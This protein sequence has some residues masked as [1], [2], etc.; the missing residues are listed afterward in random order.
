MNSDNKNSYFKMVFETTR[1]VSSFDEVESI[2]D[3]VTDRVEPILGQVQADNET[4]IIY[5][6]NS[7]KKV[8]FLFKTKSRKRLSLLRNTINKYL[9]NGDSIS[10]KNNNDRLKFLY[11]NRDTPILESV[12][13]LTKSQFIE[14]FRKYKKDTTITIEGDIDSIID[15]SGKDIEIFKEKDSWFKWQRKLHDLLYTEYNTI[16]DACDRSIILIIDPV[17]C[18]GK[19]KF[20]KYLY[21]KDR[22]NIGILNE[23]SASQLKANMMKIAGKKIYFI[24]LPR[25]SG[26]LGTLGLM[27]SLEMLKNGFLNS[28][29]RGASSVAICEPPHIV[30]TTNHMPEGNLSVDRWQCFEIMPNKDW[31]D[32]TEKNKKFAEENIKLD[33]LLQKTILPRKKLKLKRIKKDI[34]KE[35]R[36]E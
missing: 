32:V 23:A 20:L 3:N 2:V 35:V 17:G 29:F 15:Y 30:V 10:F 25:T 33:G 34:K 12:E 22:R 8:V 14:E 11:E 28:S 26:E 9:P 7:L 31:K 27:H 36:V 4:Y 6:K 19:S 13:A 24:D 18:S 5:K 1:D 21:V 16:K